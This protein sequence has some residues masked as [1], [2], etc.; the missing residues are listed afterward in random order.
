MRCVL[1]ADTIGR[2]AQTIPKLLRPLLPPKQS[3]ACRPRTMGR[4]IMFSPYSGPEPSEA[5]IEGYKFPTTIRRIRAT[6]YEHWT[7]TD[8]AKKSYAIEKAYLHLFLRNEQG[9]EDQIVA[10]HADPNESKNDKHYRY[11][12]GP[13]IHMLTAA[14][15]LHHSH[16][17]L[18]TPNLEHILGSVDLLTSALATAVSMISDQV[19]GM[20]TNTY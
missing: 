10:L 5:G 8:F 2:R 17:G 20:F 6:Y 12:A 4:L 16:I 15:P 14:D 13:H 3:L 11:K 1:D 19:L 9:D 7:P 18:N